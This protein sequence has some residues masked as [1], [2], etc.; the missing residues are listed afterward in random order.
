MPQ[1]PAAL[2]FRQHL[3]VETPEHLILDYD[4]A[5]VGSRAL[6]A[7][8]DWL[9][10]LAGALAISIG[11]GL[12]RKPAPW[13]V[14]LLLLMLYAMV[15]GYFTCFEGL[16]RGQTP[17]KRWMGIRVIRDTGHPVGFGDAAAR[18]LLLPVDLFCLVGL[19]FIAIHPRGKRIGD[20]VAGTVVVRDQPVEA[21]RAA[22]D[23]GADAEA[24]VGVA[25]G[26]GIP[27][28]S[29]EEFRLIREFSH[30]AGELPGPVQHRLAGALAVRFHERFPERP[31]D[32]GVFLLRLY[33]EELARRSG[34]FGGPGRR[35][36]SAAER[37][38]ARKSSRWDEFQRLAERVARGGLD[39]L[40]AGELPDFA[41]RY[42]EVSADLARA[43]TYGADA[44][45]LA[46][47]ERLVAA[48]HNALY[49]EERHTWSRIGDFFARDC[50]AAVV[51]ARRAVLLAALV[52]LLPGI[53][54]F[55]VLR[56]RPALAPEVL[57][58]VMLER[59]EA[60]LERQAR[61]AGYVEALSAE[62]PLVASRIL[63]NNIRVA[64]LCFAGGIVLG[65]GSLILLALNGLSI[66]AA[67]GH[68][69][70]AGLLGYLWTFVIGH[71]LL[72]LFAIWVAGAAGFRLGLA[73]IIPGELSR[74]DALVLA[75][76]SAMRLLGAVIVL[77]LVAGTI[78]G[79]ISA[80][81]WPLAVRLAVSTGSVV[82]LAL[83]LGNGVRLSRRLARQPA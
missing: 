69:A 25:A 15:W 23:A 74:R 16:R 82:F 73:L 76:R 11:L 40:S 24:D 46:R 19:F 50:P 44:V 83:Y 26:A 62:R 49:R 29:D 80:G 2:R 27:L 33:Q 52:F 47:L 12:W 13:L 60:G 8:A 64:F 14:A 6:A 54:G 53:A 56:E 32:D 17:G 3:E 65:V 38:F 31:A 68:F 42:R 70:N 36:G 63:T 51:Q 61:G 28:L 7:I 30:R 43:R 22:Q 10:L 41:A 75:G 71:G 4:V 59:S 78:E 35:R 48:G 67:S 79:F 57:P 37:L 1:R 72:E 34:R 66:G 5:G 21:P 39:A 81:R 77:L 18:N 55:A 20:L 58:D 9:I 45:S